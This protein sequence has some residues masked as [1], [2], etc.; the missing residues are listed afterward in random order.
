MHPPMPEYDL[1]VIGS[2]P[3]GQKAAIAAAKLGKSVAV[4]ERSQMLG[5]VCTNTG[6]IPS[7]TLREAVVYL[8]G[9]TQ[10]ELYGA[11][12]RVKEN[13]TPADLLARTRHVIDKEQDVVRSQL[14]RNRIELYTGHGR[15]VDEHT[16][17]VED[18]IRGDQV[19]ISGRYIIIATGTTPARPAGVEFDEERVLDS[20]GILDLKFIPASMVV[21]GAGVIG[22]EY[23]SMFAALGTR[24][25]VVE[26]RD[27]MLDF[28]DPE[29]VEALQFHLRELAVTFRFGEAVTAVDVGASGTVTTL[30]SGKQIPADAVMYSAGRQGQTDHLDLAN[31]GLEADSRGRIF[32]DDQFHTKVHHIYAIGDVIGFPALAAT[33]MEQGRLAAHH[34]FGE[35]TAGV[36]ELYPIGIYSIPEVS[37]V[38]ATEVE[39]TNDSIA[40]EVG[41]SRYR[42]LARGQIVGDSHG[43]LKLLVSPN[44]L[45]LLG[46]HVFGTN[47]TELVHIGQAVMGLGGTVEYLVDAVFNYPTFAEAYKVAA[48]DVMNKMR[49][50]SRFRA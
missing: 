45:K 39:L 32:V 50:L 28:C 10:R 18:P 46:V 5:G 22:M 31:A 11:S 13:I 4:I 36:P 41:V 2:G 40:Y 25:T 38:G 49:T 12:Y 7:K 44:D 16:V 23:A 34:A 24:V 33:S 37:Y 6:T 15:F 47:A 3:G 42:E 27:S 9:I 1:V 19:N 30:A 35:P 48:L 29:I 8:T 26:K 17:L 14:I 21:V 20:D 43:L